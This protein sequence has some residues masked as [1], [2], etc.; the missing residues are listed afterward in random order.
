MTDRRERR[1]WSNNPVMGVLLVSGCLVLVA[2]FLTRSSAGQV[3]MKVPDNG[4]YSNFQHSTSYHARLPCALCHRRQNN[5]AQPILP[6]SSN[7]APCSGCHQKQFADS[8]NAICTICHTNPS[9]GTLKSFPRLKSFNMTFNHS[10][11]RGTSCNTCHKPSRGGVALS[12]PVGFSAHNTCFQCHG[13]DAK[14]NERDISS[15]G[16]C[17]QLGRYARPLQT[18]R[19]FRVGF[20][21]ASHNRDEGLN[22]N[23][24]HR[25]LAGRSQNEVTAPQLLNHH[26]SPRSFSCMSCHNGTRAFGGDDFSACK[27]CHQGSTWRF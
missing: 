6:G 19:A 18:A 2:V 25:V 22:C 3:Q 10:Q 13:P 4:N 11:H 15:C 27:R 1:L 14:S 17:H 21:H 26:A 16:T 20:S 9:N 23:V 7:H 5:A 8:S 12:I 24:C